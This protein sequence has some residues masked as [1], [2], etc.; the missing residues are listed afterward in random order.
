[1]PKYLCLQRNLAGGDAS[2]TKPSPRADAG[3]CTGNSTNGARS[4]KRIWLTWG[5]AG[6]RV[7][8]LCPRWQR[9]HGVG[10]LPRRRN[11]MRSG[12]RA[13]R[14]RSEALRRLWSNL[15]R[16]GRCHGDLL[17]RGLYL[18]MP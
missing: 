12:L 1:M 4:F 7:W 13:A 9:E 11:G 5:T 17:G 16:S 10:Q 15:Y 8:H 14:E 2:W 18:R 6:Y 3:R